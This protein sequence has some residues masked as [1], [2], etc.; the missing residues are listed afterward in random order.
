[1]QYFIKRNN[2]YYDDDTH[3]PAIGELNYLLEPLDLAQA[4]IRLLKLE[5]QEYRC[6]YGYHD[7]WEIRQQPQQAEEF[8]KFLDALNDFSLTNFGFPFMNEHSNNYTSW[9]MPATATLKQVREF[10][11]LSGIHFYELVE[12]RGDVPNLVGLYFTGKW[13]A[14]IGWLNY[15]GVK[16]LKDEEDEYGMPEREQKTVPL[17]FSSQQAIV[18]PKNS[19]SL[20]YGQLRTTLSGTAASLSDHPQLFRSFVEQ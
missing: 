17:S 16:F 2:Y 11:D 13:T 12:A 19:L 10:R 15:T 4:E 3:N 18:S 7:F 9:M 14:Y 6:G 1:M 20:G 8:E 5:H